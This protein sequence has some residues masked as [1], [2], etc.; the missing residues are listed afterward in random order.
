MADVKVQ[1]LNFSHKKYTAIVEKSQCTEFIIYALY[2]Q[3][4]P[5]Y[6]Y[7]GVLLNTFD[8]KLFVVKPFTCLHFL[9]S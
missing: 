9:V 4:N 7:L 8:T 1:Q 2:P 3:L 5:E 6:L